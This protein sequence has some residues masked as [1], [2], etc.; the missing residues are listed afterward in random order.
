MSLLADKPHFVY[1]LR[2]SE[3]RLLY[4]GCTV[5]LTVRIA[6]HRSSQPWWHEVDESKTEFSGASQQGHCSTV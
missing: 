2:D 3:D 6:Q 4:V 1:S 5:D